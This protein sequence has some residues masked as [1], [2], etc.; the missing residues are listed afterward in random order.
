M[1]FVCVIS[2]KEKHKLGLKPHKV[3]G[4]QARAREVKAS[5][6][7]LIV[8]LQRPRPPSEAGA[9]SEVKSE[10]DTTKSK[11]DSKPGVLQSD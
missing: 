1:L 3:T 4:P 6:F 11:G 8:Y 5:Q 2:V 9:K 10:K 7:P